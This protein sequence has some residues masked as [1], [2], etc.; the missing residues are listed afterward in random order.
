[1]SNYIEDAV[2]RVLSS[3]EFD[4]KSPDMG[5]WA[6]IDCKYLEYRLMKS[7]VNHSYICDRT[8]DIRAQVKETLTARQNEQINTS[9]GET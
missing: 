8:N 4:D 5:G 2:I 9:G 1:M 3:G 7:G 6:R